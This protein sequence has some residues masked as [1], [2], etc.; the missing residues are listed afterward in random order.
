ME[1][2]H[3]LE[4]GRGGANR[5][6]PPIAKNRAVRATD[7]L[8]TPLPRRRMRPELPGQGAKRVAKSPDL[9]PRMSVMWYNKETCSRQA[10]PSTATTLSPSTPQ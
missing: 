5:F 6:F 10:T 1:E 8:H 2:G 4:T 9:A 7:N 3:N